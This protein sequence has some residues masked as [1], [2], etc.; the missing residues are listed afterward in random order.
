MNLKNH[1]RWNDA[2]TVRVAKELIGADR[3]KATPMFLSCTRKLADKDTT[4]DERKSLKRNLVIECHK[5]IAEAARTTP[6]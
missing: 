3:V 1:R 2:T 4:G 5:I 6:A